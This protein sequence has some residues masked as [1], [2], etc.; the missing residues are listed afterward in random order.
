MAT[1]YTILETVVTEE[2]APF[3]RK[4]YAVKAADELAQENPGVEFA[5][6]T[7]SGKVVH[8]VMAEAPDEVDADPVDEVPSVQADPDA[9]A[10]GVDADFEP[11]GDQ[12]VEGTGDGDVDADFEPETPDTGAFDQALA[13]VLNGDEGDTKDD[14]GHGLPVVDADAVV[15]ALAQGTPAPAAPAAPVVAQPAPVDATLELCAANTNAKRMHYRTIGVTRTA[16][17]SANTSRRA[18]AHQIETASLC[19]NCEKLA[20][21]KTVDT[22]P[23]GAARG[24][25]GSRK[26]PKTLVVDAGEIRD[27]VAHL[28]KG[29]PFEMELTDGTRLVVVAGD[30]TTNEVSDEKGDMKSLTIVSA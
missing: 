12:D 16:C 8:K 3:T 13:E 17:G 14:E 23:A 15:Q 19:P 10:E 24:G 2:S 22:R 1:K 9:E 20:K 7:S 25:T 29:D 11:E 26:S 5:V 6:A 30:P 28:K 27:L 21:G 4:E 18:N